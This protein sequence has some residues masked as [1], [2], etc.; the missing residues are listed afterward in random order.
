MSGNYERLNVFLFA[1]CYLFLSTTG[2]VEFLR[3][4]LGK[5]MYIILL[6]MTSSYE[7][8]I[9]NPGIKRLI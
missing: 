3:A 8:F 4:D 9:T 6:M 2:K 1:H 7:A 5:M